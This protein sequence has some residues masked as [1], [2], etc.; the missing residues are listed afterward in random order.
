MR[1]H[2]GHAQGT[3]DGAILAHRHAFDMPLGHRHQRLEQQ[4]GGLLYDQRPRGQRPHRCVHRQPAQRE[5][6]QQVGAGDHARLRM[7]R[8]VHQQAIHALF[9]QA[10]AGHRDAG[11]GGH[12]HRRR[13]CGGAN[14]GDH[15]LGELRSARAI[16]EPALHCQAFLE[17]GGE[18]GIVRQ[19]GAEDLR[20]NQEADHVG[21]RAIAVARTPSHHCPR[22]E[23]VAGAVIGEALFAAGGIQV[24]GVHLA[25]ED[26]HDVPG[27]RACGDDVLAAC[28][29]PH[30]HVRRQACATGIVE[31]VERRLAKVESGR[32]FHDPSAGH[33]PPIVAVAA[34]RRLFD[35]GRMRPD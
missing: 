24:E 34:R 20:R 1:Q 6:I 12:T 21:V 33:D 27:R 8:V 32:G 25:L 18:G 30:V 17:P 5:C 15:Q 7:R 29:I 3:D 13:Q 9:A 14:L 31:H 16:R 11:G 2:F 10:G 19:Q 26:H 4:V 23:D 28:V 22:T 35:L